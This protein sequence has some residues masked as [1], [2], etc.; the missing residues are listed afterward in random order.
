MTSLKGKGDPEKPADRSR[1]KAESRAQI[2]EANE[3][4]R[5]AREQG[6]SQTPGRIQDYGSCKLARGV[7]VTADNPKRSPALTHEAENHQMLTALKQ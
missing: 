3:S 5:L 4:R 6:F 1:I 7:P 2:T